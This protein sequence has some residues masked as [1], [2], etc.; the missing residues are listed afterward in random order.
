M[1]AATL[2]KVSLSTELDI[3]NFRNPIQNSQYTYTTNLFICA[4]RVLWK[5]IMS[6]QLQFRAEFTFSAEACNISF[7]CKPT[8]WRMQ[9]FEDVKAW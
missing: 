3:F 4:Y 2:L 9:V 6:S 8:Y 1:K 7:D 5:P